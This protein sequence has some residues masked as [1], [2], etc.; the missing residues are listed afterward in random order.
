MG[1]KKKD[2]IETENEF[3]EDDDDDDGCCPDTHAKCFEIVLI[4]GFLVSIIALAVNMILNLWYFKLSTFLLIAQIVPIALNFISFIVSIMLRCW[5]SDN[6]VFKKNFSSS[7]SAACFLLVL[8]IINFLSAVGDDVL[9]YFAYNYIHASNEL[10]N[11]G[12]DEAKE[13]ELLDKLYKAEK[14]YFKIMDKYNEEKGYG[15]KPDQVDSKMYMLELLPWVV[16]NVNAFM[17]FLAIILDCILMGRIKL[18]NHFGFP[19]EENNK[20]TKNKIIDNDDDIYE[21]KNSKN[22]S[23]KKRKKSS[24][25]SNLNPESDITILKKKKKSQMKKKKK[26]GTSIKKKKY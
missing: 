14:M 4:V 22:K 3:G 11:I 24:A 5:R 17:Q 10:D 19:K 8:V 7:S 6:S 2:E 13:K 23:K 9:F 12:S 16:F 20:S 21:K 18:K 25:T 26:K 15:L 1:K